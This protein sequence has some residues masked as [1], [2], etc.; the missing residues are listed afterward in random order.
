MKQSHF[1]IAALLLMVAAFA[2][3]AIFHDSQQ[4]ETQNALSSKHAEALI[5]DH[6]IL[7]GSPSAKVTIVE[8]ID[9]ACGTCAQFHP[10]VKDL[11]RHYNGKVNLVIR[12]APFHKNSDQMV[13]ILEAARKQD[14]FWE[15]L[16][17]MFKTQKEWTKNHEAK[18]ELFWSYLGTTG[19]VDMKQ[20]QQDMQSPVIQEVIQQDLADAQLLGADKT[21]TFI[22]NGKHLPSFGYEQ[23]QNL[24]DAEVNAHY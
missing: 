4:Q 8:F 21:P 19:I 20:I 13:T 9:P 23:L 22:V 2:I 7:A 14:R 18:P 15:V 6:S 11:M 1:T 12:Y 24:V 10:F 5:R 3:A 17:M 16:E